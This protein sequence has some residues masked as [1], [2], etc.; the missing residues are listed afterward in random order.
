MFVL[1]VLH[2]PTKASIA[3]RPSFLLAA[4]VPITVIN[5]S[6]ISPS[7]DGHRN[8]ILT[9]FLD[10]TL[11][12]H[13]SHTREI[14][15]SVFPIFLLIIT[16]SIR[17]FVVDAHSRPINIPS[18]FCFCKPNCRCS[19]LLLP[20]SRMRPLQALAMPIH[21][22]PNPFSWHTHLDIVEIDARG[23]GAHGCPLRLGF[24]V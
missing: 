11:L 23:Q 16:L 14:I 7:H 24:F 6:R 5:G 21:I 18:L 12:P 13:P 15:N 3:A 22:S 9:P 2:M 20:R 8:N 1:P 19:R 4:V 10:T 17:H